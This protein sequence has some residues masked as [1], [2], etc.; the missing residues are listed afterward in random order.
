MAPLTLYRRLRCDRGAELIEFALVFPL[1]LLVLFGIMD[2]GLLFQRYEAVTNAAREGARVAVLPGYAQAD[3]EARATQYL[4]A[5][6][7]TA[8]P[9]F[10]FTAP[11]AVNV[12]GACVTITGVTVGYPHQYLFIGKIISLFGGSGFTTRTLTATA[13]MRYEGAAA[14]CA[15]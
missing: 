5:A 6:G 2:F 4:V 11:Q 3:V 10:A 7:L 15:P 8:T 13:R 14:A 9:T 1:L 12:G